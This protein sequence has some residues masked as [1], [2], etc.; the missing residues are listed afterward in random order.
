MSIKIGINGFGRIGRFVFR[1]GIN[2]A[3][4]EF[5]GINDPGM[6][7]ECAAKATGYPDVKLLGK[8]LFTQYNIAFVILS[9]A[10]FAGT[11]GAVALARKIRKD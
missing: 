1:A 3:D 7:P 10:L 11:V 5:L 9:F 2:C 8:T 6:T 4:I